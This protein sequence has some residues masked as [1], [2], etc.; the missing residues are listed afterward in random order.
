[1]NTTLGLVLYTVFVQVIF[2]VLRGIWSWNA[3]KHKE[4]DMLG[5]SHA[6][7][8]LSTQAASRKDNSVGNPDD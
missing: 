4:P 3:K 2:T 8:S 6:N 7:E 1:M 5:P